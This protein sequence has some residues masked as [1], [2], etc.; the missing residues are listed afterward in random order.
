MVSMYNFLK[1]SVLGAKGKPKTALMFR[2]LRLGM[3]LYYH[4][5]PRGYS[6]YSFYFG[7]IARDL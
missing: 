6:A 5:T 2:A 1:R 3:R 4:R 7:S